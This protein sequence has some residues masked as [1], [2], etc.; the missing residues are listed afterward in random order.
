MRGCWWCVCGGV[1]SGGT[2]WKPPPR[3]SRGFPITEAAA[4]ARTLSDLGVPFDHLFEEGFSLVRVPEGRGSWSVSRA[5]KSRAR[6]SCRPLFVFH[7]RV[8]LAKD[9]IGN[10]YF[11]RATHTDPAGWRNLVVITNEFHM[12]RTRCP[13]LKFSATRSSRN[14]DKRNFCFCTRPR[15]TGPFLNGSFPFRRSIQ[16]LLL[17][18]TSFS[19]RLLTTGSPPRH[20]RRQLA[21]AAALPPS[22]L[23]PHR[24]AHPACATC[25]FWRGVRPRSALA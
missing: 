8:S 6:T 23:W 13:P 10:A 15:W 18:T 4:S 19:C 14:P 2:P 22:F 25:R 17:I 21:R 11:L 5:T 16:E 1:G 7:L 3:D 24:W 9:T 20:G 12:P